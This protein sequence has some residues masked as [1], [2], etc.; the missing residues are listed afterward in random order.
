MTQNKQYTEQHKSIGTAINRN[1]CQML[2]KILSKINLYN[3]LH[4]RS[5]SV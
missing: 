1:V 2:Q 3:F 5:H 4:G